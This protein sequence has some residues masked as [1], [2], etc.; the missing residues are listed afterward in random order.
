[1]CQE[2][3]LSSFLYFIEDKKHW[4]VSY[5]DD[6]I[7]WHTIKKNITRQFKVCIMQ[8][9]SKRDFNWL[10]Q[11]KYTTVRTQNTCRLYL[12]SGLKKFYYSLNV[13]DY[14]YCTVPPQKVE[15]KCRV[16][17]W[18]SRGIRDHPL[19]LVSWKMFFQFWENKSAFV[20]VNV[21]H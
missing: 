18:G 7:K 16:S 19:C 21:K 4:K 5:D 2:H 12:S 10:I 9:F 1:M 14:F 20:P 17:L 3:L 11:M 6:T 15:W 13:R 8:L